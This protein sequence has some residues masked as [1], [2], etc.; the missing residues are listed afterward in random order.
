MEDGTTIDLLQQVF[1]GLVA[2]GEDNK[3]HGNLAEK[4]DISPDGKTYTF[5][6][7]SGV[8][9]HNGRELVADDF[10]YSMERACAARA[11]FPDTASGYLKDIVGVK[12][13]LAGKATV[14]SGIKAAGQDHAANHH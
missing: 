4:W 6:L 13:V 11:R 14:I 9:F 5:H 8:K 1:E 7:K 10:K 3:I 2:W 12:E